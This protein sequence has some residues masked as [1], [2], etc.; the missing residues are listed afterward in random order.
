LSEKCTTTHVAMESSV[1]LLF[2]S[3]ILI[4]QSY[5]DEENL[6]QILI[7]TAKGWINGSHLTSRSGRTFAAFRGIPYA[8]AP[9]ADLR[10]KDPLPAEEWED[11]LDASQEG[12]SCTQ[13]NWFTKSFMGTEDCLKL[14]VYTHDVDTEQ[15]KPVMVWIHGGGFDMG[16]GNG[17]T[18]IYGPGYFLDR[19]IVLVTINYRLGVFGFLSTGDAKAPGNYG[20]LDQT[21][22]L[23]WVQE[24]IRSFGGDPDSVTIFGESAGGASVEFHVLSPLSSGL[25]HR[26]ISQSGSSTAIWALQR[27][28]KDSAQ[29]LAE[30]FNCS[31][32]SSGQILA[33]LQSKDEKDLVKATNIMTDLYKPFVR[34]G[35]RID[36]QRASPFL[37]AHPHQLMT[38]KRFNHVPYI[39]GLNKNEGA[40]MLA[41]L[42]AEN[43]TMMNEFQRD[44]VTFLLYSLMKEKSENGLEKAEKVLELFD[45][46]KPFD[47]QLETIDE[48]FSDA[49]F[50]KPID[51]SATLFSQYNDQPTYYYHYAH[52]GSMSFSKLMG[53]PSDT[54]VSHGDELFLMFE[55]PMTADMTTEDTQM[56]NLLIDLWTSFATDGKPQNELEIEWFPME[57]DERRILNIDDNPLMIEKL[58]FHD[59]LPFWNEL[60]DTT[61]KSEEESLL[62]SLINVWEHFIFSE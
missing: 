17:E 38:N 60:L 24:H 32:E 46:E 41:L 23:K 59:R 15:P 5:A 12:P 20:L 22:A 21:L 55:S 28:F 8:K 47:L 52:H 16:S 61:E 9:V 29:T 25:F 31:T 48:V 10:F 3:C 56:S 43:G 19:D 33:C 40:I 37:P 51:E 39:T 14:N 34:F 30:Y 57:K 36:V 58:P 49:Y 54:G 6:P 35:P 7:S 44:P 26:A 42:L 18:D 13:F 1:L 27:A 53:L 50:F 4:Q 62:E 11:V 2:I 45:V